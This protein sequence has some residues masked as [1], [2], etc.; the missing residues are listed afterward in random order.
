MLLKAY[1]LAWL[2]AHTERTREWLEAMIS[3]GFEVHHVDGDHSNNAPPNL[4][5]IDG[6]DHIRMHHGRLGEGVQ[7]SKADRVARIRE[8][9]ARKTAARRSYPEQQPLKSE[10]IAAY[11][12]RYR[13][14][15][16]A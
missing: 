11:L 6:V 12:S 7:R 16:S 2:S 4:V 5:L 14:P 1:H 13:S 9:H 10:D 8:H 3:D 15:L